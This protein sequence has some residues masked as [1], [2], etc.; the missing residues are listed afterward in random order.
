MSILENK[1]IAIIGAGVA[2]ILALQLL[3][4]KIK[5][6]DFVLVGDNGSFVFTPRLTEILSESLHEK[7]VARPVSI[8]KDKNV[9]VIISKAKKVDLKNQIIFLKNNEK[10]KYDIVVFSQGAKT[11]FLKLKNA[12]KCCLQ[13]KDYRDVEKLRNKVLS[14][15]K[16]I[17]GK[18]NKKLSIALIGGG[19]TGTELAFAL[20][21]LI[22][23]NRKKY[24][25]AR[26]NNNVEISVYQGSGTIVKGSH[27]YIVKKAYEEAKLLNIKIFTN[28]HATDIKDNT[29]FFR[30]DKPKKA[31]IIVWVA[32][33]TPNVIEFDP[34]IGLQDNAIPVRKTLQL[35]DFNNAF[36]IGDCAFSL[37]ME[38][39]PY[40]KTAQIAVQQAFH[41]SR[42]IMFLIKNK[43]LKPFNYKI[44]GY[45]LAL[46]HYKAAILFLF[47][48][49]CDKE[50]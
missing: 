20:K 41:V 13:F 14:G 46:S 36:A 26:I 42:N 25:N 12:E 50:N 28:H 18:K 43:K 47:L 9:H 34:K 38:N 6:A 15:L 27:P 33:I 4:K 31:D 32:G 11:N 24:P 7:Y 30:E 44:R 40:P 2:G 39:K 23:K 48:K 35:K 45:F 49:F 3:K 16:S 37:D 8:F 29:I 19:A 22:L 10:I 1:K 21:E 5:N 17:N